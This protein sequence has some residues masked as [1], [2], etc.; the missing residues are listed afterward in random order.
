[1]QKVSALPTSKII[2]ILSRHR[3]HLPQGIDRM[4]LLE[5]IRRL[6]QEGKIKMSIFDEQA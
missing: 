3:V 5:T 2:R 6:I 4:Q 1:M